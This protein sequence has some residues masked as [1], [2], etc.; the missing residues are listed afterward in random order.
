MRLTKRYLLLENE[1]LKEEV[2]LLK[3]LLPQ[4]IGNAELVR[5]MIR[6]LISV[7]SSEE[8]VQILASEEGEI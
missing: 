7:V 2:K 4:Q 5:R 6:K 1:R 8:L 3:S